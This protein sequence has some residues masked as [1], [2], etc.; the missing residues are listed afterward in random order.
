MVFRSQ[1]NPAW[2]ASVCLLLIISA[3]STIAYTHDDDA[4]EIDMHFD[5]NSSKPQ[6][7]HYKD[8]NP[9]AG[10]VM[11]KT[12]KLRPKSP[13]EEIKRRLVAYDLDPI[14][15]P[16]NDAYD[17]LILKV[18]IVDDEDFEVDG[19]GEKLLNAPITAEAVIE[20]VPAA[21]NEDVSEEKSKGQDEINTIPS[22]DE[23]D[24]SIEPTEAEIGTDEDIDHMQNNDS[25]STGS[26]NEAKVEVEAEVEAEVEVEA[27]ADVEGDAKADI[28]AEVEEIDEIQSSDPES[29]ESDSE[30]K[31]EVEAV[32]EVEAEADVEGDVRA[33]V[34]VEVEGNDEEITLIQNNDS[35]STESDSEAK[36][37]AEPQG[38][39]DAEAEAGADAGLEEVVDVNAEAVAEVEM[40]TEVYSNDNNK[41][42]GSA[43]VDEGEDATEAEIDAD[44]KEDSTEV[45][46]STIESDIPKSEADSQT[47]TES[48]LEIESQNTDDEHDAIKDVDTEDVLRSDTV[49]TDEDLIMDTEAPE[50]DSSEYKT[51]D[52]DTV[53]EV[54]DIR[55]V[56][57][58]ELN[59]YI[60]VSTQDEPSVDSIADDIEETDTEEMDTEEDGLNTLEEDEENG[61]DS[62]PSNEDDTNEIKDNTATEEI[63]EDIYKIPT[64]ALE[65]INDAESESHE[66]LRDAST[67]YDANIGAIETGRRPEHSSSNGES[68]LADV[69]SEDLLHED[70][71]EELSQKDDDE[72]AV[73][74]GL[75]EDDT[76]SPI[77]EVV[78][79]EDDSDGNVEGTI[80][81]S[82]LE[83]DATDESEVESHV[84]TIDE[85]SLAGS[86]ELSL[87]NQ[88]QKGEESVMINKVEK[89]S[90]DTEA[91]GTND[92]EESTDEMKEDTAVEESVE[93][94][95]A[96]GTEDEEAS[97]D[98]LGEREV[99]KTEVGKDEADVDGNVVD[100]IQSPENVVI[101]DAAKVVKMEDEQT[102]FDLD[103]GSIEEQRETDAIDSAQERPQIDENSD[104]LA[105]SVK[106]PVKDLNDNEESD[107]ILNDDTSDNDEVTEINMTEDS[108]A[109]GERIDDPTQIINTDATNSGEE[110]EIY[111]AST[112]VGDEQITSAPID[113]VEQNESNT[114]IQNPS[115]NEKFVT[116]L[117]DLHKF[118][119]EV[120]PPDELDVS[121]GGLSI[122]E[123][124]MGQGVA[125]IKTRVNKVVGR[126]KE[127]FQIV[128]IEGRQKL[129][130]LKQFLEDRFDFNVDEVAVSLLEKIEVP[131]QNVKEFL[132]EN[133]NMEKIKGIKQV[134]G[135]VIQSAKTILTNLG[136]FDSDE[137]DEDDL[138]DFGDFDFQSGDL[139]EMRRKL[140]DR[141]S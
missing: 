120:D 115:A 133:M 108:K 2:F 69:A 28:E 51:A 106:E 135:D 112:N 89:A 17:K 134:V 35:E 14:L 87:G 123:V 118:L 98:V 47:G 122:Q 13:D 137:E 45:K 103:E 33:E 21:Y 101:K 94:I 91:T 4:E 22:N 81:E 104:S 80:S 32:V 8:A 49:A 10:S 16:Y 105:E 77:T 125:I 50:T 36:V 126:V 84:Q 119:E 130:S 44:I 9:G 73:S 114:P 97:I 75:P 39:A 63:D 117:D 61:T 83:E 107:E 18:K 124:L 38:K 95:G 48:E 68:D 86:G 110:N 24:I 131:R 25:E 53:I 129:N 113:Y 40:K 29:T 116:G 93:D 90:E 42:D 111:N 6:I 23:V 56:N 78:D 27:E 121:A 52:D 5:I 74:T 3:S 7:R 136:I 59:E 66:Q 20:N 30:A 54:E 57:D 141:Y 60:Q 46:S 96:A 34:E 102:Y 99:N 64:E 88:G 11:A 140:M 41:N 76:N 71:V 79:A 92:E 19:E 26:D 132:E 138:M 58:S 55:E 65:E 31:A 109:E 37:E 70:E 100:E 127:S 72:T 62:E 82:N 67:E 15:P 128:R 12:V 139:E 1:S 43:T 85:D